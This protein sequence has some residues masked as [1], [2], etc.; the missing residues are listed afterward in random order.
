MRVS[1]VDVYEE[2]IVDL[3]EVRRGKEPR[4]VEKGREVELSG[5]GF[6]HVHQLND[7]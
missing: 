2:N 7:L 3:L 4:L 6:K 1:Y 5:V